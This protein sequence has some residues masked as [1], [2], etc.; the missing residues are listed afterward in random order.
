MAKINQSAVF[1]LRVLEELGRRQP[2][3]VSVL[4]R[5]L[6]IPKSN[7]QRALAT[8]EKAGWIRPDGATGAQWV[9]SYKVLAVGRQVGNERH[10]RDLAVPVIERLS[11]ETGETVGMAMRDGD[12]WVIVEKRDGS[13]PVRAVTHVGVRTPL[14]VS[15][16]GHAILAYLPD[17]EREQ[18]LA[19]RGVDR[20]QRRML[21]ERIR[22]IR[23]DRFAYSR[24]EMLEGVAAVAAP[25]FD[26]ADRPIAT[27][28]VTM[29]SHRVTQ[30]AIRK[31][32]DKAVQAA[33][34]ITKAMRLP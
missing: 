9:L 1:T 22:T 11:L 18:I 26:V 30:G 27:L 2:I 25:I 24:G 33:A 3:G 31:M 15:G 16:T 20:A 21:L 10:L 5:E 8:L 6:G 17:D 12:H 7:V 23:R 19:H 13:N 14:E 28:G 32:G 34:V 29:P 4:A